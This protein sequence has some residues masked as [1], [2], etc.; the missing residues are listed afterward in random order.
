LFVSAP[1][2]AAGSLR[3][4][5]TRL[6]LKLDRR[7][8]VLAVRNTGDAP[9]FLQIETKLWTQEGGTD[10]Y[11]DAN[12]LIVSPPVFSIDP[13]AEQIVRVAR[14]TIDPPME[15]K[16]YRLFVQEVPLASDSGGQQLKVVLRIGVP[17]FVTP[18]AASAPQI[19]WSMSC[20]QSGP[21][22]LRILNSGGR[23]LRFDELSI[24]AA[25]ADQ[26]EHAIYVLAGAARS[27]PITNAST[28]APQVAVLG[29]SREQELQGS[30]S[31]Q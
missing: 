13:G 20:P 6:D 25:G 22:A 23:A 2:I 17:V 14:R 5:P 9:T 11:S 28:R 10:S 21:Q 16:S 8:T 29:K 7:A 26:V 30:A 19:E 15:E 31:C 3:V 12:D 18:P 27:I 24:R 4:A 1:A